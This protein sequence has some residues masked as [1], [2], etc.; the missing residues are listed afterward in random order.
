MSSKQLEGFT[1]AVNAQTDERI[2]EILDSARALSDEILSAVK[3][4]ISDE[5]ERAAAESAGKSDDNSKRRISKASLE[6]KQ[7]VLRRRS[8]LEAEL[9]QKVADKLRAYVQCAGYE[10]KLISDI[11]AAGDLSG[12]TLCL[13]PADMRLAD[14]LGSCGA[15][16]EQDTSIKFGGFCICYPDTGI[17]DDHTLD[18]KFR[19]LSGTVIH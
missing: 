4:Q 3:K 9:S 6:A 10:N 15:K 13:S 8:E 14:R 17:I 12:A 16:I 18:L 2:R 7:A 11:L 19:D 1:A 5:Q